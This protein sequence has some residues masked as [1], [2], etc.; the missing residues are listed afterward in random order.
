MVTTSLA[1]HHQ[2]L[3][4]I[5]LCCVADPEHVMRVVQSVIYLY[6]REGWD[7][8]IL[9]CVVLLMEKKQSY[10]LT[11]LQ[12]IEYYSLQK[13]KTIIKL[14]RWFTLHKEHITLIEYCL[15]SDAL[16]LNAW[17]VIKEAEMYTATWK[18]L[19]KERKW[20]S[21]LFATKRKTPVIQ[22]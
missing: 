21:R 19:I 17:R 8:D 15:I 11:I 1:S 5:L 18:S 20:L 14:I 2:A 12:D 9:L 16:L 22:A 4:N 10:V 7:L 3:I 6:D 13:I